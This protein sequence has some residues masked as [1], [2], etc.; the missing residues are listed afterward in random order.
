MGR[1][2]IVKTDAKRQHR[3]NPLGQANIVDSQRVVRDILFEWLWIATQ[4]KRIEVRLHK[5]RLCEHQRDS[6][7]CLFIREQ[8]PENHCQSQGKKGPKWAQ[9]RRILRNLNGLGMR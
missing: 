5:G 7:K 4:W 2:P 1:R 6:E 3:T 8:A 9:E